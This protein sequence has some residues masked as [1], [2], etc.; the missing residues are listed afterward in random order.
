MAREAAATPTA[1]P[2]QALDRILD[3]SALTPMHWKIWWLSAMG[4]FLD[5]FDLFI[6][7]VALPIIVMDMSP[8]P[9][10][11]GLI[12]AT[13]LIGAMV[14]AFVGGRLTDRLGRK[15]IYLVDLG[16]FIVFSLLTALA[17]GPISLLILRGLLG[18]GVGADYPICASYVSEFMPARVRGRMLIGA[19]S[20]QA[21]GMVAAALTGL[22]ILRVH[23]EPDAWRFM[24]AAAVAPAVVVL[25][26]RRSVPESARWCMEHGQMPG[27]P[28]SWRI[29]CPARRWSWP[30]SPPASARRH[31]GSGR[32][33]SACSSPRAISGAPCSRRAPG[34]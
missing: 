28:G 19:F 3:E 14:G 25:L 23:P 5:G 15:S 31:G 9:V 10:V 29:S 2:G 20:F 8:S 27:P 24:L 22:V 1:G 30:P 11:E 16:V 7:A 6:I 12:G 21:L 34:S 4:V 26:L 32:P 18:I 17:P 13:A 33:P